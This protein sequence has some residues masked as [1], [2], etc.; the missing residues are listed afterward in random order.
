MK[1]RLLL[2][3]QFFLFAFFLVTLFLA[4]SRVAGVS[5][6]LS[7]FNHKTLS[8][9]HKEDYDAS[10]SRLNSLARLTGY[11][12]SLYATTYGSQGNEFQKE[13]PNLVARVIRERFY[14]GYSYYGIGDNYVAFLFSKV[15]L[16]GYSAIVQ[17]NDILKH[18][19][20]SCSQQSIIMMQLL[21][22]KGFKTRKISF[23][24][25]KYGGHFCF[26]TFYDG[27][28][29]F[30]DTNMEPD[31]AVLNAYS[32]PGI[33]F[34]VANPDILK[35]AYAK[36]PADEI[37]DIFPTYSYG[38][39]NKFPAPNAALFQM[40]SNILSYSL[41]IFFLT[42]FFFARRSYKRLTSNQHVWN[43]RFY[44]SP[45]RRRTASSYNAGYTAPWS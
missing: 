2:V 43:S 28:W 26:E 37:M 7:R 40:V 29:H 15:S 20:A 44:F 17:P 38:P 25:K 11:C 34:L 31:I 41:W 4:I 19:N 13:Y 8:Y 9:N 36:Y 45:L 33:A 6:P 42:A 27:S 14:H 24:G 30:F 35:K 3:T 22:K 1:K 16:Q 10:L 21:E 12:D 18:P 39:V 32:R 23:Q 5:N